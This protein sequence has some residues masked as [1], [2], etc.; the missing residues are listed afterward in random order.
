MPIGPMQ[1]GTVN[2]AGADQT[3]LTADNLTTTL[4]VENPTWHVITARGGDVGVRAS[5]NPESELGAGVFATGAI[6]VFGQGRTRGVL[7][8]SF[9]A[10]G[11]V[12]DGVQGRSD[13]QG[14]NA[15]F[16]NHFG[17]GVGVRGRCGVGFGAF[18]LSTSSVG[19]GGE[20]DSGF[21]LQGVTTGSGFA[22]ALFGR[23]A[24]VGNLS[25]F[26]NLTVVPPGVKSMAMPHSDGSYRRLY[27][28]ESPEC[29]FED[30]GTGE[31]VEGGTH[32]ELDPD[33]VATVQLD[34]YHVFLTPEGD[35]MGLYIADKG[36]TGF[37]VR[38]QQ[39]GTSS[40]RFSYRVAA[41]RKTGEGERL[42]RFASVDVSQP[43]AREAA[44]P[45]ADLP[46]VPETGYRHEHE[47]PAQE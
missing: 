37:D 3:T 5:A 1:F 2:A 41:R 24:V 47:S 17:A 43:T 33:Y 30:F 21:G 45:S 44:A 10:S 14:R 12:G 39:G 11:G 42:E 27:S 19:V 32:I 13:V 28:M 20:S 22:G 18:G 34:D 16:G 40:L 38:E 26:G 25:V 35:S 46:E 8:D 23:T 6:G 29:W 36:P 31:L 9:G 15:V 4:L 7:G